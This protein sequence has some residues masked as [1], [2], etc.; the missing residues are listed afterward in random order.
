MNKYDFDE[1]VDRRH[2]CSYKWK[3]KEKDISMNIA[4]MDFHVFNQI[5][6]AIKKRLELDSFG[7]SYVSDEFFL[8]YQGWWE[9]RHNIHVPISSMI[10][11]TGVVASIDSILK[12]AIPPHSGVVIQPPVY[13]VF[14][15][16]VRNNEHQLLENNLLY[17]DGEYSID[18]D[19][20]ESLLKEENTKA[21]ILCNPHNP[22]GRIW[23]KEELIKIVS[24]C[25]KY[26]ILLISD[27]IHCDLVRPGH[28]YVPIYSISKKSISLIAGSKTFNIAG[29]HSS[30]IV[31]E[32]KQLFD[33]IEKG[34]GQDD[35]GEID[36]FAG[37]A[38]IA[39]FTLGD[40]WVDQLNEYI[41]KNRAYVNQF[42]QQQLPKLRLIKNTAT[43]LLWLD[44]S[45]YTSDSGAFT[46]E[47]YEKKGLL[48]SPG[49]QFGGNGNE[50]VRINI[51]TSKANVIEACKR[52]KEFIEEKYT[53]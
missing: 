12:H 36:Y 11:S 41:E 45:P 34:V 20:L 22:V 49:C 44:I 6:L 50:F 7:Y 35:I 42:I 30:V 40:E 1:V 26:N 51:A 3:V 24:L 43:Y 46:K 10:F 53:A 31:C 14:F 13:H 15:N 4:D 52:L 5:T 18:F 47:L 48:F 9:R 37:D 28:K 17:K 21:M 25:E 2:S 19:N 27:E 16:C 32:D 29:L 8:A 23:T 38:N 33:I 39:A